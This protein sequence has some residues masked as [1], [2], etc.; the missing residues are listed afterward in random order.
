MG[1]YDKQKRRTRIVPFAAL[2]ERCHYVRWSLLSVA[3]YPMTLRSYEIYMS[4]ATLFD[5]WGVFVDVLLSMVNWYPRR[6]IMVKSSRLFREV[7]KKPS[8]I[9]ATGI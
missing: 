7:T 2:P 6:T 1:L 9:P 8:R 5:V 4:G 3:T